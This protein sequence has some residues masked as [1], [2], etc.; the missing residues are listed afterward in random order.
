MINPRQFLGALTAPAFARAVGSPAF[1][2]HPRA[3]GLQLFTLFDV[4][5]AIVKGTLRKVAMIGYR[6]LQ[7]FVLWHVK[8]MDRERMLPAPLG[9]GVIDF[10]PIFAPADTAGMQHFY[11]EH[12]WPADPMASIATSLQYLK[13]TIGNS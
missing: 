5:D 12:D 3:F 10:R 2:G 4:I 6:D 11:V 13:R 8:D 7:S 1:V 9:E